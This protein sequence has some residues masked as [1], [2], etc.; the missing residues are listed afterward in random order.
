MAGNVSSAYVIVAL[1]GKTLSITSILET[2]LVDGVPVSIE[3]RRRLI[4]YV[5]FGVMNV[6]VILLAIATLVG[7]QIG[8]SVDDP[9]LQNLFRRRLVWTYQFTA[10]MSATILQALGALVLIQIG[11]NVDGP[12][13]QNL[14]YFFATVAGLSAISWPFGSASTMRYRLAR[15]RKEEEL[16][17]A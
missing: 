13:L 1:L 14:T 3:Y 5:Y 8:M 16:R 7:V 10:N 11:M 2:G 15:I 17:D 12:G 4:W 6:A 9:K